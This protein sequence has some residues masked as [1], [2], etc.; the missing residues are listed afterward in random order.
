VHGDAGLYRSI[1]VKPAFAVAS[2]RFVLRV[3][4]LLCALATGPAADA[5]GPGPTKQLKGSIDRVLRVLEDPDLKSAAKAAQRRRS[6]RQIA[7]Q[8]FDFEE[9]ARP[10]MAQHWRSLAPP[11]RREFV[12]VFSDL[13]E[14]A[15]MWKI[16]L[17]GGEQIQYT[18]E[19][20]EGGFA[21]VSTRLITKNATE[22]PIDTACSSG[23]I[24]GWS[25]TSASRA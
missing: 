1:Q 16:E 4:C 3:I 7:D 21:T 19:R 22:V 8:I 13:L 15:Y 14:R 9:T 25:M 5:A 18:G 20:V 6:V 23:A 12:D 24:G 17:Y 10:A 2:T 11:Q